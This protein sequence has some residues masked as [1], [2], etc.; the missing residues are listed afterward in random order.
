MILHVESKDAQNV[1]VFLNGKPVNHFV[2][3]EDG[4]NGWIEIVDP[5]AMAP[6]CLKEEPDKNP[7]AETDSIEELEEVEPWTELKLKKIKG[8]VEFKRL[9]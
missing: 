4:E 5:A 2:R 3:A 7:Y 8:R 1:V 6:P 9:G